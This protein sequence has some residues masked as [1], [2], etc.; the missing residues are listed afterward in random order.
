[1]KIRS[2]QKAFLTILLAMIVNTGLADNVTYSKAQYV[3]VIGQVALIELCNDDATLS[4]N[5]ISRIACVEES[6]NNLANCQSELLQELGEYNGELALYGEHD[7]LYTER[8]EQ[9]LLQGLLAREG[10]TP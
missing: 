4:K 10:T 2:V 5:N 3:N 7:R 1:M 8:F 6:E 9:C